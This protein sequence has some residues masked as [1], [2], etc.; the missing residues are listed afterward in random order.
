MIEINGFRVRLV[1]I[2][3]APAGVWYDGAVGD[4]AAVV[5]W[6]SGG[7]W[8]LAQDFER[9]YERAARPRSR[10]GWGSRK[11]L[12]RLGRDDMSA[13]YGDRSDWRYAEAIS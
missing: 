10:I 9:G 8:V 2:I 11:S 6:G 13:P 5:A 12:L 7:D 3:Y 1:E 4:I